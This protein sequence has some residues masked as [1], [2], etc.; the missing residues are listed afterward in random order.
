[1]NNVCKYFPRIHASL[2]YL[3]K[4]C[5]LCSK[6]DGISLG[7]DWEF[8][9]AVSSQISLRGDCAQIS[10]VDTLGKGNLL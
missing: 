3:G 1:M 4:S 9:R 10:F 6:S 5:S 2:L 7:K 8:P